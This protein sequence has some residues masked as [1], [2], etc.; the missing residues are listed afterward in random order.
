M[1]PLM[2]SLICPDGTGL[3]HLGYPRVQSQPLLSHS[4]DGLLTLQSKFTPHFV[5]PLTAD[6]HV[7][8][9]IFGLFMSAVAINGGMQILEP[10]PLCL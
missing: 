7:V 8:V 9:S 2:E 5:S 4:G 3:F 10:L 1:F 6:G